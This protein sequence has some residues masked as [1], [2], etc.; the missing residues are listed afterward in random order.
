MNIT[1]KDKVALVTGANRGMGKALLEALVT[2]GAA[3]VYACARRT[4]SLAELTDAHNGVVVPIELDVTD[5]ASVLRAA[6]AAPD[7]EL[8][9]N[10]AGTL[11]SGGFRQDETVGGLTRN[12]DVNLF[13]VARVTDAFWNI[14]SSKASAA[15]VT[16][17]SAAS[18]RNMSAIM[19][20]SVS[21]A[22]VHS[23]IQGMRAELQGNNVLVT[24]V[25][26]GPIDTDMVK[27]FGMANLPSAQSVAEAM[28]DGIEA[29]Q[30]YIFPDPM[31][32]ELAEQYFSNPRSLED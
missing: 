20:Y 2:R 22:A 31:S 13:G 14:I 24:G 1:I 29:G 23:L 27:S 3:K 8:L 19:T 7:V 6:E 17:A 4:E 10:N 21:K 25:Y 28:L 9:F 32:Q 30:E 18:L 15:I 26:P 16:T 12:I 5:E 11:V